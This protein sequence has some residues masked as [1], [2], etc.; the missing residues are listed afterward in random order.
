MFK[1][2]KHNVDNTYGCDICFSEQVEK[3]YRLFLKE[4]EEELASVKRSCS[5]CVFY[6]ICTIGSDCTNNGYAY[7]RAKRGFVDRILW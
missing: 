6:E 7:H 5:S 1:C 3:E 2:S 4:N